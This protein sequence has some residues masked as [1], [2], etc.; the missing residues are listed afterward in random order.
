M[1]KLDQ[2]TKLKSKV[3]FLFT[4]VL[5]ILFS[6]MAI[7]YVDVTYHYT[8]ENVS[9]LA[10]TCLDEN[11]S[12]VDQNYFGGNYST[13]NGLLTIRY[14]STLS[15]YG[16]A[17][18][19]TTKGRIP[20]ETDATWHSYGNNGVA[21]MDSYIRFSQAASCQAPVNEFTIVKEGQVGVPI[22]VNYSAILDANTYSAFYITENNIEYI[23]PELKDEYYSV[24][25]TVRYEV[26]DEDGFLLETVTKEYTALNGNPIFADD[27]INVSFT[28][29]PD[30][31]GL[32]TVKIISDVIDN[33]CYT[34]NEMFVAKKVD[35]FEIIPDNEFYTD[36]N[37][38]NIS[39]VKPIVG[40]ELTINFDK[41]SYLI[42]NS[43]GENI[44]FK[45]RVNYTVVN[46]NTSEVIY[47]GTK[48]VPE[49]NKWNIYET[50]SFNWTPMISGFYEVII[51][52]VAESNLIKNEINHVSKISELIHINSIPFYDV[53][54]R[55]YDETTS[56]DIEDV[57]VKITN[58]KTN[59]IWLE[60]TAGLGANFTLPVGNYTYEISKQGYETL[61]G[62][63]EIVNSGFTKILGMNPICQENIIQSFWSKWENVSSCTTNNTQNFQRFASIYDANNCGTFTSYE[64][65]ENKVEGCNYCIPNYQVINRV[66]IADLQCVEDGKINVSYNVKFSDLNNCSGSSDYDVIEYEIELNPVCNQVCIPDWKPELWGQWEFVSCN[67]DDSS[68][69]I[70][71]RNYTDVN[72]CGNITDY[73]GIESETIINLNGCDSCT[74]SWQL[75]VTEC[76]FGLKTEYYED[77]NNCYAQTNLLSDLFGQPTNQ[78]VQCSNECNPIWDNVQEQELGR[79]ACVSD[80]YRNVSFEIIYQ[81]L[82]ECAA[83]TTD[84]E[85]R[86]VYDQTCETVCVPDWQPESW[87]S[88]QQVQCNLDDSSDEIRYRNY[89]DV[90]L[91]GNITGYP[92]IESDTRNNLNGCDSCTPSWQNDSTQCIYGK[93]NISY[94]DINS[95]FDQTGLLSDLLGW[96]PNETV[97]CSG[98]CTNTI[99]VKAAEEQIGQGFCQNNDYRNAT[100]N[101]T[102]V[103]ITLCQADDYAIETRLVL[104]STC[105]QICTPDYQEINR[106]KIE[107]LECISDRIMNVSYNVKFSDLN[108]CIGS[109]D[110]YEID[111]KLESNINCNI[112][113]PNWQAESWSAGNEISCYQNDTAE[114][115][116]YRDYIDTNSCGNMS[117]YPG[118]EEDKY[119]VIGGCDFCVPDWQVMETQCQFGFKTIFYEDKNSC[120]DKTN[121]VSDLM[122]QPENQTV[123]CGSECNSIWNYV[124]EVELERFACVS[125]G[126]RNVSYNV[127]YM[128]STFC[129]ANQYKLEY[130][131]EYDISCVCIPDLQYGEWMDVQEQGCI[132]DNMTIYQER[133]ITDLNACK[134]DFTEARTILRYDKS[135]VSDCEWVDVNSTAWTDVN[136]IST[137]QVNQTR[138]VVQQETCTL[139]VRNVI[140]NRAYGYCIYYNPLYTP[141]MDDPDLSVSQIGIITDTSAVKVGSDVV[142]TIT[143]RNSGDT[144]FDNVM[145]QVGIPEVG[146]YRRYG[147]M[148]VNE[149]GVVTKRIVLNIPYWVDAGSYDMRITVRDEESKRVHHRPIVI[150]D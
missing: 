135:C 7:A 20:M 38:I 139:E 64:I 109:V 78:T 96:T 88:W 132:G 145:I 118:L 37:N 76:H 126:Y 94:Y 29:I 89:T 122:E 131:I 120:Y 128:D 100:Y 26:Y 138:I 102:Y 110:F 31:A 112:C 130:R 3:I 85:Y 36:L 114:Y 137:N 80:G 50:S 48:L 25:T 62:S 144:D 72:L 92:G 101:V 59:N 97:D 95:C 75:N 98:E 82:T 35:V 149:N 52:G 24:D 77:S 103:D 67:Q 106:I 1:L 33:Q 86:S 83:N 43:G 91:C 117:G 16:Y 87:G 14:P 104:D 73:P 44:T 13:N 111:F 49:N 56:L 66:K 22:V 65:Y 32:Y 34:S 2:H 46:V 127:S 133:T 63:F 18:F 6:T 21:Y 107:D 148:N 71:Y 115:I 81:D 74:P 79:F 125:D 41:T 30:D 93:K 8:Q 11:C 150:V 124:S 58:T 129:A 47:S 28:W 61:I 10:Y 60:Y 15:Q 99:W 142:M 27:V 141:R 42:N 113:V 84:V 12:I 68:N 39:N 70:R 136:C 147:P 69:M 143:F 140:E 54:F 146:I 57:K 51:S 9:V 90:N 40:D 53:L 121:L 55:V 45:T 4:I 19:H 105:N 134:S 23:P 119:N 17:L 5:A 116:R 123:E 108:N